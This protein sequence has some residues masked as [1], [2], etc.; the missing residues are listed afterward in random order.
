[1]SRATFRFYAELNDFLPPAKRDRAFVE[2][3]QARASIKDK[4]E[5]I[6][7]PHPEVTSIVVNGRPVDFAHIVQDGD[8]VEVYP[9][10][11]PALNTVP[12][13]RPLPLEMRF[14]LDTHQGQLAAYLR[15]LG[16]DTLYRNDYHD[17]ELARISSQEERILLTRDRGLLKRRIVVYGY[18]VRET[19]PQ[20]QVVE[21]L[22]RFK[23]A[24][25]ISPL[26][27]CIGCNGLLETVQKEDVLDRI[28]PKTRAYFEEFSACTACDQI[29]W[30]GSHYEQMRQFIEKVLA[31]G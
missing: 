8:Q 24:S 30:K 27:R 17:D 25:A 18:Y 23:L 2:I 29:Y 31:H 5:S 16:F 26:R 11:I 9:A 21:L 15:M 7:V 6:G 14:V 12:L 1:M 13:R 3:L 22:R 10:S 19:D 20:R 4:I 28:E